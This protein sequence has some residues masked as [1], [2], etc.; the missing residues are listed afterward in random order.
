MYFSAFPPTTSLC[1]QTLR[2]L[3]ARDKEICQ[4]QHTDVH[5]G[6]TFTYDQTVKWRVV[7]AVILCIKKLCNKLHNRRIQ[8]FTLLPF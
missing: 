6:Q 3:K 8:R 2:H 4:A 1:L 7:L 5:T